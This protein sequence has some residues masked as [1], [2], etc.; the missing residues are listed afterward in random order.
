MK[1]SSN[2]KSKLNE[3]KAIDFN[4]NYVS[5]KFIIDELTLDLGYQGLTSKHESTLLAVAKECELSNQM[6]SMHSGSVANPS[7]GRQVGHM[8]LRD[9]NLS[10]EVAFQHDQMHSLRESLLKK[11]IKNAIVIGIGGSEL[12]PKLV[13]DSLKGKAMEVNI[14]F[15]SN[16]D[17]HTIELL[18]SSYSPKDTALIVISKTFTTFETML[19]LQEFATWQSNKTHIVAITANKSEACKYVEQE[20]ILEFWDWVGGR[21]SIWSTV[22]FPVYLAFGKQAYTDF[23]QGANIIDEH[24]LSSDDEFNLPLNLSLH[25]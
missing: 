19:L 24:A 21:Y 11:N 20:H 25:E 16:I 18:K 6:R 7:E 13:L 23:L 22:F 10:Q 2:Y 14:E 1:I 12:G 15:C 9:R 17:L 8:W 5:K 4:S 3:L